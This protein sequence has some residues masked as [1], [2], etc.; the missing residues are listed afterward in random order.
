M[1]REERLSRRG[2]RRTCSSA[3]RRRRRS[4]APPR[5]AAAARRA[6]SRATGGP[7]RRRGRPSP[8]SGGGSAGRG[9]GRR[10]RS[11]PAARAPRRR[12]CAI[13][14]S[15]RLPLVITSAPPNSREQQVVQRRVRQHQAEPR[16]PRGDRRRDAARPAGAG[17]ARS[18]ARGSGAALPRRRPSSASAPGSSVITANGLSSR[19][20]RARSRATAA[21]VRGVAGEVVAAEPLDREDRALAEQRDRPPRA[22][23]RAAGPQTGQAIGSAWKRRSPG[24]SYSRRQSAHSGKPAIVVFGRSYGTPRTI[25]KRGPHCVQLMNG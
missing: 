9:R 23:A 21:L 25:V 22:A 5:R 19:C 3:R 7:G 1:R 10:R 12:W 8:R 16:R 11:R 2:R 13:G 20:L 18:A 4:G 15:E 17:R 14:S 24:S 6:R